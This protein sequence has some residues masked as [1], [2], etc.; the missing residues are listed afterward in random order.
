MPVLLDAICLGLLS[1]IR[2]RLDLVFAGR[3]RLKV[4]LGMFAT[5][6]ERDLVVKLDPITFNK[7]V[8]ADC[9]SP[10]MGAQNP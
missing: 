4:A 5:Q 10:I 6:R 8:A 9:A 7:E 1:N 2:D 3:D